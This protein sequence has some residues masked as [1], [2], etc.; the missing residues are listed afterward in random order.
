MTV[1][2]AKEATSLE[3]FWADRMKCTGKGAG[4]LASRRNSRAS[5]ILDC[6][7]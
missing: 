4:M 2:S 7:Q 6:Q 3:R 1:K 5:K